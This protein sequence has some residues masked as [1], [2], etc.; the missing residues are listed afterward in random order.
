MTTSVKTSCGS[1][2]VENLKQ[3]VIVLC[4]S[5]KR[6]QPN[7]PLKKVEMKRMSFNKDWPMPTNGFSCT[8]CRCALPKVESERIVTNV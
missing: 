7:A 6:L 3:L 4:P 5:K 1:E 2:Q 8:I